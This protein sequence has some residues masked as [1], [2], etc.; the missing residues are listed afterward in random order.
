MEQDKNLSKRK[1]ELLK[2]SHKTLL[3]T[4]KELNQSLTTTKEELNDAKLELL[5]LHEGLK[6]SYE[7][8][9]ELNQAL[10]QSKE[11]VDQASKRIVEYRQSITKLNKDMILSLKVIEIIKSKNSKI[12]IQA[13]TK[14]KKELNYNNNNNN[15]SRSNNNNNY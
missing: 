1:H 12:V 2:V 7:R 9:N 8:I 15:S 5:L 13:T 14:A 4:N 11:V 3:T 10:E 6:K